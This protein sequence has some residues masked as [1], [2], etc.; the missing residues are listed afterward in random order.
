[1]S[2]HFGTPAFEDKQMVDEFNKCEMRLNLLSKKVRAICRDFRNMNLW[3]RLLKDENIDNVMREMNNE[4]EEFRIRFN[5]MAEEIRDQ[6]N[7]WENLFSSRDVF[8]F[9]LNLRF[10]CSSHRDNV[11]GNLVSL[12]ANVKDFIQYYTPQYEMI[13]TTISRSPFKRLLAD[14][15]LTHLVNDRE[16]TNGDDIIT[17]DDDDDDCVFL[18]YPDFPRRK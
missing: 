2:S 3:C 18:G 14:D 8:S 16:H 9:Q 13:A 11:I 6:L 5:I 12:K 10:Q 7:K 1:M 15:S 4:K 17:I